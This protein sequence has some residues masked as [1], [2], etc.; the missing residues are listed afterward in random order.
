MKKVLLLLFLITTFSFGQT[1]TPGN[2]YV[3]SSINV[4]SDGNVG[5]GE[6]FSLV[7]QVIVANGNENYVG[8]VSTFTGCYGGKRYEASVEVGNCLTSV[9]NNLTSTS[10]TDALSAAQ[11]KDLQRQINEL[12]T[13]LNDLKSSSTVDFNSIYPVGYVYISTESTSPADLFG[14]GTWEPL[15]EG[16]VLIG[17]NSTYTAGSKGGEAS[18]TLTVNEMPSHNHS[19][20]TGSSGAHTPTGTIGSNGSHTHT[21]GTMNITGEQNIAW[22]DSSAAGAIINYNTVKSGSALYAKKNNSY[23]GWTKAT[24]TDWSNSRHYD[25]IVFDASRNWTGSTSSSGS[26]THSLS[27]NSVGNHSHSVTVNNTGSG[28]AHNNMQPYLAVYMWKRT[29]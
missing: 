13:A 7:P 15:N 27:M 14:I 8:A 29:A 3:V 17:A 26:H 21:R 16:R 23:S 10:E 4:N 19:A 6:S 11:G 2:A 28:Q 25:T 12:A 22:G 18:H 1:L 5:L 20:S 9:V 24:E